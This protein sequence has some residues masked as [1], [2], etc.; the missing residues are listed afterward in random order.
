[1]DFV[2]YPGVALTP[3]CFA[4]Q[5]YEDTAAARCL[6]NLLSLG[7][8]RMHI[9][10]YWDA[11]R[12]VW[13]LCPVQLGDSGGSGTPFNASTGTSV[14]ASVTGVTGVP[15]QLSTASLATSSFSS[16]ANRQLATSS[17]ALQRRQDDGAGT[18]RS[19]TLNEPTASSLPADL[20]SVSTTATLS[21]GAVTSAVATGGAAGGG[22]GPA[23]EGTLI[24]VGP[25]TCTTSVNFDL[26][27]GVLATYLSDTE[28]DLNATTHYLVMN[29]HAAAPANDPTAPAEEPANQNL[30]QGSNILSSIIQ[31]NNS[32]YLYTYS[33]LTQ[34]RSNLD[35]RGSWFNVAPS[36]QPVSDYF[37]VNSYNGFTSTPDGW[38]N[39]GFIELTKAKRLLAAYGTID[40]QMSGYDF[41]ADSSQIFPSGYISAPKNISFTANGAVESGCYYQ[42][43]TYAVDSI[44]NSWASYTLTSEPDDL[45]LDMAKDL[46][47]CGLSPILNQTL[48]G[49]TAGEDF[50][51]YQAFTNATNWAWGSNEPR[52]QAS[53]TNNDN[54]D[55]GATYHCAALNATLGRWQATNCQSAHYGACR[56]DSAPYRWSIS[57]AQGLYQ[58]VSAACNG[59]TSFS[60]P[61]TALENSYLLAAWRAYLADHPNGNGNT[62]TNNNGASGSDFELLWV[63]FNDLDANACWVV[64]QNTTCPYLPA[65]V[66]ETR[67]VVVPVVAAVIVF[68]CFALTIFVKC[69]AN[70][71]NV[72]RRKRRGDDGWDYEGVPS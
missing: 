38:P 8:R 37:E 39:E 63:D 56:E 69:T 34:Q 49:V 57:D 20:P 66:S 2:N 27:M 53:T 51:P 5:R 59:N 32:A 42:P 18:S 12:L 15:D 46:T 68:V 62:N 17:T 19:L 13:S 45:I 70:R 7:F 28:T 40:P 71:Q 48:D 44:H 26:F 3:A 64:G 22:T 58:K 36:V 10:L 29:L 16:P 24:N 33:E 31:N 60:A 11:S 50:R 65:T 67:R 61:R 35:V 41:P 52:R 6:S 23:T 4:G 1:M 47:D 21:A 30:P 25:Y 43:D 55:D 14:S 72:K 54:D 9:D